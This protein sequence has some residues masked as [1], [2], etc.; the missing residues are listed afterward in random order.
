MKR[1]ISMF[2]AVL[3]LLSCIFTASPMVHAAKKTEKRTIA[4]VFDNSGSMYE[5]EAWCRAT[6]AM[7]VFAAMLNTGDEL[8]IYPMWPIETGGNLYTMENPL[9]ITD[10]SQAKIIRD[11]Y[12]DFASTTP[13]ES[14]EKAIEGLK[15][16]A[17]EKKYLIVLTDGSSFYE[18]TY[19]S[20]MYYEEKEL[21]LSESKN[22]LKRCFEDAIGSDITVMYLGISKVAIEKIMDQS[23]RYVERKADD[24]KVVL[25]YLTELCNLTFGRDTLPKSHLSG[26]S[27][28]FDIS[29]NKVIV[30]V[31]GDNIA[32]VKLTGPNGPVGTQISAT[33]TRF[34][35]HDLNPRVGAGN[36]PKE[37]DDPS[38]QGMMVT[39]VDC[40]AGDYTLEYTGTESSVEIYY[41]P[42]AEMDFVFTD[43][44]GNAVDTELLYEGEYKVRYGM[45]DKKTGK[46]SD[47]D[48]LGDTHYEGYYSIN[49]EQ[50][51]I[52][53]KK[54]SGS[55][56]MYLKEGDVFNA[57]LTVTYLS[58][59]TDTKEKSDFPWPESGLVIKPR[60]P[61]ELKLEISGGD[62]EY[63][64]QKLEEGA[65][66][67]V[68][69]YCENELLT[70]D[71][72]Q[73]VSLSWDTAASNAR[74]NAEY[75]K[76]HYELTLCYPNPAAPQDTPCGECTVPIRAS[77]T[78]P[79]SKESRAEAS[80]TYNIKDDYVPL[81]LDLHTWET[82]IVISEMANSQPI[83]ADITLNGQPL[84]PEEFDRVVLEVDNAG[85]EC[86]VTPNPQDSSYEIK[87]LA[88][89]GIAEDTYR[90]RATA[91][92]TDRVGRQSQAEDSI[93]ITLSTMPLW[94]K[95]LI[96]ALIALLLFILLWIIL[97]IRVLPKYLHTT[98]KLSSMVFD[99]EDVTTAA[100]FDAACQKGTVK[101]QS[102]YAGRKFGISMD[103]TP[104]KESYLY[105]SQ[106]RRSALVKVATV[107]KFGPAKI[108]EILIGSAKYVMDEDT[109]KLLPAIP[110]QKPFTLTNGMMVKYS[111][112]IND[113]GVDK[114]FEVTSKLNFKKKK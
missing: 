15:A 49:G 17:T 40:P 99:G 51:S 70:G 55:E 38:L 18:K 107:R 73:S 98:R 47:S 29:M 74:I 39:Y 2:L 5:N 75:K 103:V 62:S 8:F 72:L 22:A 43:A 109:G 92:Y 33:T 44:K 56:T 19:W 71:A 82:Y 114:D 64:L 42:N 84:T 94:M 59:Y 6:Y 53:C 61:K 4:I 50:F 27:V 31:Q 54:K 25:N 65:P 105:K 108:Q 11:I 79:G 95:W 96:I 21:T 110:N 80:L 81:Q 106:K 86:T 57:A 13:I 67:I 100:S 46:L 83:I 76:D 66:F 63:P 58:G 91:T 112:V 28:N 78:E 36:Y 41:E 45:K 85:I 89:D 48:L 24:T 102:K 30:F 104:G 7:E 1:S 35:D 10:P 93:A 20:A 37:P 34:S 60:P 90:I 32:D 14:V 111:G 101:A 113:A 69:V 12:T 97:H 68:K 16:S 3:M 52:D 23:S 9:K 26:K 87:L 77:Y 88:N